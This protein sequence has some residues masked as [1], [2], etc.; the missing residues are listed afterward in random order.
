MAYVTRF[1]AL[2][3]RPLAGALAQLGPDPVRA[4]RA[5]G[6]SATRGLLTGAWPSIRPAALVAWVL[7]FLT[8]LHELTVSSLL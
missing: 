3:H 2:G 7:V 1:W 5:S 8:T 4:A 6:A